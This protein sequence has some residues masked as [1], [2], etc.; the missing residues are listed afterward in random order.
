M[1]TSLWTG[2]RCVV[3]PLPLLSSFLPHTSPLVPVLIP[4]QIIYK[5]KSV[6]EE[7]KQYSHVN[8]KAVDMFNKNSE[9]V[10][11]KHSQPLARIRPIHLH[12]WQQLE[13]L[14]QKKEE[15]D[16]GNASIRSVIQVIWAVGPLMHQRLILIALLFFASLVGFV[17]S[18]VP[19]ALGY[20]EG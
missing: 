19:A 18:G 20:E 4:F 9:E 5:L 3:G 10:R 7:L 12:C 15:V 17:V 1:S 16:K 11:R 8:R 2:K 6:N 13:N 14:L